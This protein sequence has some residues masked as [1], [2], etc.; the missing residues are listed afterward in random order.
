MRIPKI[1]HVDGEIKCSGTSSERLLRTG[2]AEETAL[3]RLLRRL[4]IETLSK[5]EAAA[6]LLAREVSFRWRP[7]IIDGPIRR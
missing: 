5:E 1:L 3:D 2:E 7:V 4:G 6:D